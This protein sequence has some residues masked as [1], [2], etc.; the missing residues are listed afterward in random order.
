M[1]DNRKIFQDILRKNNEEKK[2]LEEIRRDKQKK[3]RLEQ[4]Q[5]YYIDKQIKDIGDTL[6]IYKQLDL[7]KVELLSNYELRELIN[8]LEKYPL[9]HENILDIKEKVKQDLPE[10]RDIYTT[11]NLINSSTS[12]TPTTSAIITHNYLSLFKNEKFLVTKFEEKNKFDALETNIEFVKKHLPSFVPDVSR[13]FEEA[14][15]NMNIRQLYTPTGDELVAL[16]T[17]IYYRLYRN[18]GRIKDN[19]TAIQRFIFGRSYY[20]KSCEG[21]VKDALKICDDISGDPKYGRSSEGFNKAIF[22]N[23]IFNFKSIIE[24]RNTYYR[25]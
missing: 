21:L 14:T 10:E 15:Y 12:A 19:R 20:N 18:N 7:N 1:T 2:M 11:L 24:A 25:K 9:Y 16:R 3:I 23:L 4:D 17:I 5:L 8:P 22:I 13:K 6:D